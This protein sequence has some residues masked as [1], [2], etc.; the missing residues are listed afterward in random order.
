MN[1]HAISKPI[2]AAVNAFAERLGMGAS[3]SSH[4]VEAV[5]AGEDAPLTPIAMLLIREGA[6]ALGFYDAPPE[7]EDAPAA[8][9]EEPASA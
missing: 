7:V 5:L 6:R 3:V 9:S 8:A 1:P 4:D 2:A